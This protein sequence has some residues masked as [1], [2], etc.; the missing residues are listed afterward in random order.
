MKKFIILII[1]LFAIFMGVSCIQNP[2]NNDPAISQ[3]DAAEDKPNNPDINQ[4]DASEDEINN[5]SVPII[6][7]FSSYDELLEFVVASK[8]D[9]K[10]Y[11]DHVDKKTSQNYSIKYISF[12]AA[13]K[14]ATNF[15]VAPIPI[16]K[17]N[18]EAFDF[19]ATYYAERQEL[20]L[21]YKID[22]IRYCFMYRF[23]ETEL[24]KYEDTPVAK[25][26]LGNIEINMYKQ[27]TAYVGPA[28]I[29]GVVCSAIIYTDFES[30]V[31]FDNFYLTYLSN[32]STK[33]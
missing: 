8:G 31:S 6:L 3:T 1:S 12:D 29:D 13:K 27:K 32:V 20:N 11:Q 22:G 9:E 17:E 33:A 10:Q 5:P 18:V 14:I 7:T 24:F 23:G 15:S 28:F 26:Q 19:G 21:H 30:K 25:V 4:T 16:V 2:Q